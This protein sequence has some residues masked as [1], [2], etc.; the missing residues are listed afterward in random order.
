MMLFRLPRF[1]ALLLV[2]LLSLI[3]TLQ[4]MAAPLAQG[5]TPL[6]LP[7]GFRDVRVVGGLLAPRDFVFLPDGRILINERGTATTDDQAFASVRVVQNGVLL[8]QRAWSL[9]LCAGGE[10]G[11]LGITADPNFAT[12]GYVYVFYTAIVTP[13]PRTCTNRISRLTMTAS[14]TL[15]SEKVL[16]T[17]I[18]SPKDSIH[19]AG[20]IRFDAAGFLYA[21]TGNGGTDSLSG[22]TTNLAGKVLRIRP[23]NTA[24]GY[25]TT[26]NPF[27]ATGRYCG[28]TPPQGGS[29]PCREILAWGVRNPFRMNIQPSMAGIPGTNSVWLGDVGDGGFEE[30]NNVTATGGDFGYPTCEGPCNSP[31]PG[32]IDPVYWYPHPSGGGAAVIGGDF[33]VGTNY[34]GQ[35]RNSYYFMDYIAGWIKRLTY[36]PTNQNWEIVP[37]NFATG[38]ALTLINLTAGPNGDLLYLNRPDAT[39]QTRVAELRRIEY[40]AGNNQA[41]EATISASNLNCPLNTACSFSGAG[42]FDPDGDPIT[43]NWRVRYVGDSTDIASADNLTSNS[44][45]YTFTQARNAIVTLVVKDNLQVESDP[46][47]ITVYPGNQ[48]AT[49]T[50]TLENVT[51]PGGRG[52]PFLYHNGDVWRFTATNVADPDGTLPPNP[53][54]WT[55]VFHHNDHTHPFIS[56]I[57]AP[58]GTFVIDRTYHKDFQV[59]Y[60][61]YMNITDAR[62]FVRSFQQEINPVTVDVSFASNFAGVQFVLDG[63]PQ[64]LPN[65]TRFVV[66]TNLRISAPASTTLEGLPYTFLQWADGPLTPIRDVVIGPTN[67]TYNAVYGNVSS[68]API[69]NRYT[70]AQT[71][72]LSWLPI[73]TP[74]TPVTGYEVQLSS[75]LTFASLITIP[76]NPFGPTVTNFNAPSLTPG[77]YY[78]RVRAL[79]AAPAAPGPWSSTEVFVVTS[80]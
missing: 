32:K 46:V 65:T 67:F 8:P 22:E 36:N 2:G 35:Y 19:N 3:L 1:S 64:P 58:T 61:V 38:P 16:V 71:I 5:T 73:D 27:D 44:W 31:Q 60:R 63:V 48:P 59:W 20:D 30:V 11:L 28:T 79:R 55:V 49:G 6:T 39:E 34:P 66:G 54:F 47:S 56:R 40:G 68:A 41:P 57:T 45:S 76:G 72:N 78:W 75:S 17:N 70:T 77:I 13:D 50:L 42:S 62:G 74:A 53:V 4:V 10:Q 37:G 9:E 43:Y 14:N 12:N 15:V 51:A 23:D 25:T 21:S 7:P 29:Q 52:G 80:P 26:G 18:F 33:Y 24:R 69:R